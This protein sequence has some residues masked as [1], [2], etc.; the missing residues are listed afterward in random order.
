MRPRV[1]LLAGASVSATLTALYSFAGYAMNAS[2]SV[3]GNTDVHAKAATVWGLIGL[4][5]SVLAVT[6]AIATWRNWKKQ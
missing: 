2:F 4:F 6:S 3:N 1:V 5:A